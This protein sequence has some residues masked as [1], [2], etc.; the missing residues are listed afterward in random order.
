MFF[1]E[2][3]PEARGTRNKIFSAGG[4]NNNNRPPA[5]GNEAEHPLYKSAQLAKV[6]KD[7]GNSNGAANEISGSGSN[8]AEFYSPRPP[9]NDGCGELKTSK[10]GSPENEFGLINGMG[11]DKPNNNG[12]IVFSQTG[13]I[14]FNND[15]HNGDDRDDLDGLGLGGLIANA[16]LNN[17][18][19]FK[20]QT[21]QF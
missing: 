10:S 6:S 14:N 11:M 21:L 7:G 18:V 8:F 19:G 16:N 3:P 9:N 5:T 20:S 17:Q 4:M 15:S 12:Q 13:V 2:R 1:G